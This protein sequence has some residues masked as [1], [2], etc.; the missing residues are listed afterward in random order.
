MTSVS[1][2][3]FPLA[4]CTRAKVST[5]LSVGKL[6]GTYHSFTVVYRSVRETS[7]IYAD[8]SANVGDMGMDLCQKGSE[9][10][11]TRLWLYRFPNGAYR[12]TARQSGSPSSQASECSGSRRPNLSNSAIISFPIPSCISGRYRPDLLT[13]FN[14][15]TL[16]LSFI[17]IVISKKL[18]CKIIAVSRSFSVSRCSLSIENNAIPRQLG[19]LACF[20]TPVVS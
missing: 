13:S 1:M 2:R 15:D 9:C 11:W 4:L 14:H 17:A 10:P 3:R 6:G 19:A 5:L 8:K 16:I 20:S 18:I 7:G 12:C